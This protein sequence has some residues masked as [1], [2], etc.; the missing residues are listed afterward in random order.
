MKINFKPGTLIYP[1]PAVMVSCGATPEDYNIIT[2]AWVGTICTT[3][4]MCY[5][6]LRP[7]RHSY[8]IIKN[9]GCFVINLTTEQLA[10]AT[11]WCGVKSGRDCNKFAMMGLTPIKAQ[12]VNAPIIDESPVNIECEVTEIKPLG[13]HDMFIAKVVNIQVNEQYLNANTGRFE[14]ERS[15]LIT[16]SH[17]QYYSIGKSIG[18]F[19]WSVRKKPTSK[20]KRKKVNRGN[21]M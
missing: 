10:N 14:L 18:K 5:I 3:P 16:Y 7:S 20:R 8:Q 21:R 6:S 12:K 4:P 2:V 17:G 19:G 13:S 1:L 9:A 11:D 15:S